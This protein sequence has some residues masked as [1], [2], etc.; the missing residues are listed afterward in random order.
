ML[1]CYPKSCPAVSFMEP[2]DLLRAN[3]T[4]KRVRQFSRWVF[5]IGILLVAAILLFVVIR[6]KL[7]GEQLPSVLIFVEAAG[8]AAVILAG[9]WFLT[10]ALREHRESEQRYR[11]MAA[12]IQEIFW[13]IDADSKCALEVNEAYE[14]IMGRTRES[15]MET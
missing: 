3:K 11:E 10:Q 8:F 13:M 14:T 15:L 6:S 9:T 5:E 12:N 7:S 4:S 2:Q 1:G